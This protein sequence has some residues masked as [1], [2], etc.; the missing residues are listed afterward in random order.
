MTYSAS[1]GPLGLLGR[2]LW[3]GSFAMNDLEAGKAG[4]SFVDLDTISGLYSL[5]ELDDLRDP[6]VGADGE[7]LYPSFTRGKTITYE[8]RMITTSGENLT[9]YRWSMLQAFAEQSDEGTMTIS[10]H[11]SWGSGGWTFMARVLALEIDDEII[12]DSM[13]KI[14]TP[15][16][17]HF[18]LSLRMR[19]NVFSQI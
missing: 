14:P 12:V 11:P 7:I 18:I 16:Q 8:G 17:V 1:S 15:Y 13:Q 6:R 4:M 2:H 19:N 10:P 5:P 9:S 3:N